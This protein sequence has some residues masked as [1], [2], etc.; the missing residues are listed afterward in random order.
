[1]RNG[2]LTR[3]LCRAMNNFRGP[4]KFAGLRNINPSGQG[5]GAQRGHNSYDYQQFDECVPTCAGA[6]LRCNQHGRTIN[7]VA[8]DINS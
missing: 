3:K 8:Q 6:S 4:T 7:R 5:D 1:M 2:M